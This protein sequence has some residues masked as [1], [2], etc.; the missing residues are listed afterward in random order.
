M[1]KTDVNTTTIPMEALARLERRNLGSCSTGEPLANFENRSEQ[2]SRK[3]CR[4]EVENC[5]WK[6]KRMRLAY[7]EVRKSWSSTADEDQD[8]ARIEEQ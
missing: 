8:A 4:D 3:D 5:T 1:I 7:R 6:V 2:E